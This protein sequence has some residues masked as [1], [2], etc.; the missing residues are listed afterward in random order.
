MDMDLD[1]LDC[2]VMDSL[3][4]LHDAAA[5]DLDGLLLTAVRG[6]FGDGLNSKDH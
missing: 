5:V 2:G 6:V 1:G 3:M 4:S